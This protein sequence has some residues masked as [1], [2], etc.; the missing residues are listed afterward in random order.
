MTIAGALAHAFKEGDGIQ[1]RI[2]SSSAGQLAMWVVHNQS[3]ETKIGPIPVKQGETIDFVV[4]Y[5]NGLNSDQFT[6][7][8]S[9]KVAEAS[10]D[11]AEVAAITWDAKKEFSGPPPAPPEPLTGWERYAQVLLLSNEFMFFD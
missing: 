1:S 7:A 3:A 11:G 6:W 4:D 9:I 5:R 8:P 2:V 10:P